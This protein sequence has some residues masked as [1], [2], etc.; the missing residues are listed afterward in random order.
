MIKDISFE[1]MVFKVE[2]IINYDEALSLHK[3]VY[4]FKNL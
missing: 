3:K 1:N 2:D 4:Y